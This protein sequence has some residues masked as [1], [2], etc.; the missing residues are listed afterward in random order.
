[1][2]KATSVVR[3]KMNAD[4]VEQEE[5]P[6]MRI[7]TSHHDHPEAPGV[8]PQPSRGCGQSFA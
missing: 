8:S 7:A 4:H 6:A 2:T 1:M 5:T 3:E